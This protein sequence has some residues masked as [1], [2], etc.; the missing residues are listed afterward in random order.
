[1]LADI[2]SKGGNYLLNVGPTAEGLFPQE[3][4]DRLREIG[5][6]MKINGESIYGTQASPFARLDWGRCT[7]KK[8]TSGTRLF[9]HVF[10]KPADGRLVVP[11]LYND[12]VKVFMLADTGQKPL[13]IN[14]Q[15]DNLIINLRD[16][17]ADPC[18][19]VVAMDIE[20]KPDVYLP[21]VIRTRGI[22]LY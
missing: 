10:D 18:N 8:T 21:P 15:D 17:D 14:R 3:S 5:Q 12:P 6:W 7:Q 1:M 13:E 4:I 9:F 20:G 11:G 2:A 16:E 19:L 22:D